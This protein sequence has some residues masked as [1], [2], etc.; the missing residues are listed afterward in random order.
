M[1]HM[2]LAVK[3]ACGFRKTLSDQWV[4]VWYP[5]LHN[6]RN[7]HCVSSQLVADV[8]QET[9]GLAGTPEKTRTVL[10]E[11]IADNEPP[12]IDCLVQCIL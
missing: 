8:D 10:L 6:S 5:W 9:T 1:S 2:V 4:G 12:F 11:G 7:G 3:Q